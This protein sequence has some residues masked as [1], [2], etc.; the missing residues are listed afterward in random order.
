MSKIIVY[1]QDGEI[2]GQY[3]LDKERITIGRKSD[4]DIPLPH[5]AVSSGH[6][7]IIT[8]RNDSFLEDRDSTNGVRVN[9]LPVKKCV[10]QDGD[11]MKIGKYVLKYIYEELPPPV[12]AVKPIM[13]NM[14]TAT[15]VMVNRDALPVQE[16]SAADLA[17][18]QKIPFETGM[19]A[20]EEMASNKPN[21]K[22]V[23]A[24]VRML[25]GPV[26]GK[27]LLLERML[28]TIGKPGLQVAVITRRS[29]GYFLTHIEGGN[30]PVV[31]GEQV[32]A[33]SHQLKNHDLIELAGIK[34]EFFLR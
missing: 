20:T 16:E 4:S 30:F 5:G 13:V 18:T 27:E 9:N 32:G 15:T 7:L 12:Q 1:D 2:D 26:A 17:T 29:K 28:T 25:N 11:E 23:E 33:H 22:S 19:L 14:Q 34:M 6:A 31:N 3:V 21:V 8:I 24:G 10:L